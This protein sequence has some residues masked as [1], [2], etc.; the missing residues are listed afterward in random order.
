M[1]EINLSEMIL[2]NIEFTTVPHKTTQ[3]IDKYVPIY[4][5]NYTYG[6]LWAFLNGC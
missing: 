1:G 3:D 4:H 5:M 6:T 2:R